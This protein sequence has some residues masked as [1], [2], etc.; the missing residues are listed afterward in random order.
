MENSY[1]K[2]SKAAYLWWEDKAS[3]VRTHAGVAFYNE[4]FNE[5]RLIPDSLFG[6]KCQFYCKA[7]G[8]KDQGIRYRVEVV[9][10]KRGNFWYRQKVGEGYSHVTN[11]N[12]EIHLEIPP[13]SSGSLLVIVLEREKDHEVV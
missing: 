7:I 3:G 6:N 11:T 8:A 13:Y 2:N 1:V 4:K 10:T 5:Y 12:G 9:K